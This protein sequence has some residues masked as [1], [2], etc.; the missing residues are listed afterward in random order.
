MYDSENY[1]TKATLYTFKTVN[2]KVMKTIIPDELHDES[3][4]EHEEEELGETAE[5]IEQENQDEPEE[6]DEQEE[7]I[8]QEELAEQDEQEEQIE[9]EESVDENQQEEDSGEAI[10]FAQ[11]DDKV[12]NVS[13]EKIILELI[14]ETVKN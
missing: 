5:Q 13:N 6:Q 10:E 3:D 4:V 9:Q 2:K 8:E 14:P 7:Q 11:A 12:K 1:R